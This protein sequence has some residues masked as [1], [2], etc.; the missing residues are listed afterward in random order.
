MHA[1]YSFYRRIRLMS[2]QTKGVAK[3]PIETK[4]EILMPDGRDQELLYYIQLLAVSLH[5]VTFT[6]SLH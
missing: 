2:K 4:R 5:L 1:L 6:M 3:P